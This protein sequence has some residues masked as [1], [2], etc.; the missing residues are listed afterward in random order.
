MQTD[1]SAMRGSLGALILVVFLA[2][3]ACV[4]WFVVDPLKDHLFA[5]FLAGGRSPSVAEALR[6][7]QPQLHFNQILLL[8]CTAALGVGLLVAELRWQIVSAMFRTRSWA[9]LIAYFALV[10]WFGHSYISHGSLLSGD[11]IAHVMLISNRIHAELSGAFPYWSNFAYQGVPV[12]GF[13]S[14]S[15]YWPITWLGL[16]S[17]DMM[18][19]I[20]AFLFFAHVLS[21]V[22]VFLLARQ[23][24]LQRLGAFFAGIAYSGA[25]AHLHM[26]LYRGEL[27]QALNLPL[28]PFVFLFLHRMLT[29]PRRTQ[30]WDW[31]GLVVVGAGLIMNYAPV[32]VVAAIYLLICTIWVV[33]QTGLRFRRAAGLAVGGVLAIGLAAFVLV[34]AALTKSEV[35]PIAQDRL[36]FL[37]VPSLDYFRQ[38]LTWSAGRTNFPGAAG[39]LGIISV[40][41]AVGAVGHSLW[42]QLTGTK[43]DRLDLGVQDE[44]GVA[45]PSP[46]LLLAL[47]LG[48]SFVLRGAHVRDIM[49][50]LLFTALLTGYGAQTLLLQMRARRFAPALLLGL[51]FLDLGST[52]VQPV[53]RID[54]GW[55]DAAG[56]YLAEQPVPTRTLNASVVNGRLVLDDGWSILSWYPSEF[57]TGAGLE[58]ATPVWVYSHLGKLAAELDLNELG[59]LRPQMRELLCLM[60]VGRVVGVGRTS[61]GLPESMDGKN[62]GPLG[63]VVKTDCPYQLVFAPVLSNAGFPD[64]DAHLDYRL[65]RDTRRF[66]EFKVFLRHLLGL[67]AIDPATGNAR[68]ILVKEPVPQ[69]AVPP[70]TNGM[71]A[72]DVESYKVTSDRVN[73]AFTAASDGFVLVSHAWHPGLLVTLNGHATT[74]YRDIMGH[75]V[76]AVPKGQNIIEIRA[77]PEYWQ[78]LG[79]RISLLALVFF[80][81][82][83]VFAFGLDKFLTRP[84]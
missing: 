66:P 75:I 52:S 67:M 20:K 14:P 35:L 70:V 44:G 6:S 81:V 56:I 3:L 68:T 2:L 22:G 7:V 65:D 40:L 42:R 34:P 37:V 12:R 29:G 60:R 17:G 83:F 23:I 4:T 74:T 32:A 15:T 33:A 30:L 10:L 9:L 16:M 53:A 82:I 49:F 61:M 11:T 36:I 84:A 54:K 80:V 58:L 64:I 78:I 69:A 31:A 21:G 73:I 27:T 77:V 46:V 50:T 79:E 13:Y 72:I 28:L 18:W 1:T 45:K 57:L 19:G 25:F 71:R 76:L 8:L 48:V 63:K 38:L 55:Q 51:F 39:Y 24:G 5:T 41:L 59:H 47:L 43:T 26:I 62:E